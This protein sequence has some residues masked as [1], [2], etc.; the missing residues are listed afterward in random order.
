ME[1]PRKQYIDF[2]VTSVEHYLE[3]ITVDKELWESLLQPL[4]AFFTEFVLPELFLLVLSI[5]TNYLCKSFL[6]S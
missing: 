6:R 3:R 1:L 4:R 2:F 5:K